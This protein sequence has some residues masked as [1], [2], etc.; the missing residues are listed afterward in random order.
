MAITSVAVNIGYHQRP[1]I[2]R[3]AER[4]V[5]PI[6]WVLGI[7]PALWGIVLHARAT[8]LPPRKLAGATLRTATLSSSCSSLPWQTA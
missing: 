3:S 7:V 5:P 8:A 6:G 1:G 2:Y 4:F